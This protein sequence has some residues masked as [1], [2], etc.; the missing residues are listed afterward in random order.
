MELVCDTM[1]GLL[2]SGTSDGAAALMPKRKEGFLSSGF[3]SVAL[4]DFG[5]FGCL[6]LSMLGKRKVGVGAA[7]MIHSTAQYNGIQ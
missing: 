7:M 1:R 2:G 4:G 3:S 5:D 6:V